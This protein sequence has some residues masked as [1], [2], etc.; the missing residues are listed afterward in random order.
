MHDKINIAGV[1][2]RHMAPAA[3]QGNEGKVQPQITDH[4]AKNPKGYRRG[5][6]VNIFLCACMCVSQVVVLFYSMKIFDELQ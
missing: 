5:R 2:R 1:T 4:S 3:G 6:V